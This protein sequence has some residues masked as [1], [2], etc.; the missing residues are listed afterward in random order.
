[1]SQSIRIL[2]PVPWGNK[3]CSQKGA[4]K[5][6]GRGVARWVGAGAIRFLTGDHRVESAMA[7][8]AFGLFVDGDH[9]PT[10]EALRGI[11]VLMPVKLISGKRTPYPRP[12]PKPVVQSRTIE[13]RHV[14]LNYTKLERIATP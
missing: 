7:S 10:I 2:N 5:H 9:Y 6:V 8:V 4:E 12:I 11:P 1:L 13:I 3:F 14:F